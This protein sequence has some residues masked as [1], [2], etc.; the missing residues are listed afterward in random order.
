[1]IAEP[2][3]R[4]TRKENNFKWEE[5]QQKAFDK[6]KD[7]LTSEPVLTFPDYSKPFHVFTDASLVGQGG[8]LMQ[9]NENNL[10]Q[11]I[12][13]CSRTL[14][15]P[16]RK[17]PPVQ[18]E[19]GAI[20]YALR[21][22]KPFIYMTEVELHT[23]HKPLAY[24]LEK[25]QAHPNLARWLIELQNYNIKIVHVSGKENLLADALSRAIKTTDTKEVENLEEL[26][27]IAEFPVCLA[28]RSKSQL[29]IDESIS[30]FT[31]RKEDGQNFT[32]DIRH[33]QKEDPAASAFIKF[34]NTGEVPEEIP[35]NEVDKFVVSAENLQI[36]SNI[37]CHKLPNMNPRIFVP[38]SLRAL[39]FE[40][41][42][43]SHLGG[44]HMSMKKT[45]KKC[46]KYFWHRMH[47]DI[48][49]WT[50]NCI[51]CQLRHSPNPPYRAEMQMAPSNT[52]FAKVGIDLAG[53]F[54]MTQSGNKY[55][56]N[57]IYWFTKYVISVP[58]PDAKALTLA[59]AFLTNCYLRFGGCIELITD[60]ATAFTSEFFKNF[61][62]MLYINKSYAIPHWSQGNAVTERSFRT[63]HNILAK[64][65]NK[66]QPDFDEFIDIASFCYN[67]SI[68]ASTG[69]TPF[70][71]MFG[72]DPIFCID[73]I[74]DPRVHDPIALTDL[75]EF[76][77]LLVVSLRKAW[78]AAD[79]A[80]REAQLKSKAQYD[81]LTRNPTI[82]VGDRVLL[83]NYC[84]KIG[85][86]KKFHMP[87]KGVFRVVKIDGIYVTIISCNAPSSIPKV[88]HINQLKKC[89]ED[90][91]PLVTAPEMTQEEEDAIKESQVPDTTPTINENVPENTAEINEGKRYNLRKNPKPRRLS[92]D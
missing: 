27:D 55:I 79:Q 53:P 88:V 76:K 24:L 17:W 54:P 46:R 22:F 14:T 44:G 6:I 42:H 82:T 19:L 26:E 57:I 29:I 11:A 61:C 69:E 8:A 43:S 62:S 92:I 87:W 50:R 3:T 37:L 49:T 23:D 13:Y 7:I 70:F 32:I 9:K 59:K 56:M 4:L 58:V 33:E 84:G 48:L 18:I 83:R 63:F 41:F 2:L 21:Q 20:I 90:L 39:I 89:F 52:L 25:A 64:Y 85:T 74:L 65:I 30:S 77:Q 51:T 67:T 1:M 45:L 12:A 40:S 68:H 60:N 31:L 86:S 28:L 72:R 5:E 66:E 36:I 75:T 78:E 10:F 91:P 73:Q 81:K 47:A 38:V 16:E 15:T 34:L 71:L 35:P 80:N